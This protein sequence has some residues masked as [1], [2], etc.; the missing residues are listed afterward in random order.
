MNIFIISARLC[1]GGSEHVGTML[2]NGFARRCHNVSLLANLD[3]PITYEIDKRIRLL[4]ILG[5]KSP[6]LLKWLKSII[7]IRKYINQYDP[8]VI[9]G[10]NESMSLIAHIAS[11]G[12]KTF[13]ICTDHNSFEKP[14]DVPMSLTMKIDKF[15]I[16]KLFRK[17]T[18]LTERDKVAIGNRLSNVVVMPNPLALTPVEE[19]PQKEKTILAAGRLGC[20]HVKGFDI[21]IKAWGMIAKKYPDWKLQIAG[22][23][24]EKETEMVKTFIRET[25]SP[26]CIELLGF[27]EDIEDLYRRSEIFV[28]SSRYE[29]FGLVLVEAMSQGCACIAADYKGRQTEIITDEKHGITCPTDNPLKITDAIE[30]MITDESYR[31][32]VQKNSIERAAFYSLD[33]CIDRWEGL[34]NSINFKRN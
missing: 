27:R 30:R 8:D 2:A 25:N 3:E 9:I 16:N 14:N 32:D 7:L 4:H 6:K 13:V 22:Y 31:K 17:V 23:G 33:N 20:W 10:I 19:I 26:D 34:I 18:V 21:L 12:K 24:D 15:Y 11:I 5:N 29:G 1:Y 28:L